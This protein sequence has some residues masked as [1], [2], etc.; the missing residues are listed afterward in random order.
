MKILFNKEKSVLKADRLLNKAYPMAS[1][2]KGFKPESSDF[3]SKG[4]R[5]ERRASRIYAK[6]YGS[7]DGPRMD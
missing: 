1:K 7:Y 5:L 6:L 2:R 3:D 4:A